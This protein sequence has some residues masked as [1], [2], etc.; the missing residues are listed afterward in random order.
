MLES[1]E[2]NQRT[3]KDCSEPTYQGLDTLDTIVD[4]K[5]LSEIIP[6]LQF[7]F[8]FNR[9]LKPEEWKDMDQLL[10][11]H[12]LLKDVFQWSMNNKRFNL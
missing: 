11:L 6:N 7:T 10:Q 12:Q 4:G 1:Q 9:N 5:T 8:Q 3:E 2:T